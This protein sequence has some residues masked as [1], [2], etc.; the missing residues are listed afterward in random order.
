MENCGKTRGEASNIAFPDHLQTGKKTI[1]IDPKWNLNQEMRSSSF[2]SARHHTVGRTVVAN[3]H[4]S[5]S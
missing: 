4:K 5:N 1:D 2:Q 3:P